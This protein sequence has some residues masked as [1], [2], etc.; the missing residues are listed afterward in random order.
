MPINILILFIGAIF[1][2][3]SYKSPKT[4]IGFYGIS[5][6]I[7]LIAGISGLM[8]LNGWEVG[9]TISYNYT[10]DNLIDYE[11][12]TLIY[13]DSVFLTR[14]IPILELLT[15]LYMYMMLSTFNREK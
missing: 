14:Y 8:G 15:A 7:F 6:T 2:Y 5:A 9:E 11:T 13:S 4:D 3:L 1:Y 10:I 12:H